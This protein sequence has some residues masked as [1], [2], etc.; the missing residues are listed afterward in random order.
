M[1]IL[2]FTYYIVSGQSTRTCTNDPRFMCWAGVV[3][4]FGTTD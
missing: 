3:V 4:Q 1:A 2:K